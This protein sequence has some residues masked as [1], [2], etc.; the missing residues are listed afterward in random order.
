MKQVVAFIMTNKPSSERSDHC[1]GKL[2]IKFV[3][4]DSEIKL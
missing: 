2:L 4:E 1:I 3:E